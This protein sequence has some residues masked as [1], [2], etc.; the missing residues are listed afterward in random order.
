M[1]DVSLL[2]LVVIACGCM[3]I[4]FCTWTIL[5]ALVGE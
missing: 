3:V 4:F 2:D 5:E 1:K